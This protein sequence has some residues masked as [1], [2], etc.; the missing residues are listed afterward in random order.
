[1]RR[2][3]PHLQHSRA[4]RDRVD[5]APP[6]QVARAC[7]GEDDHRG[8]VGRDVTAIEKLEVSRCRLQPHSERV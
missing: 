2:V 4:R 8:L 3:N 5:L 1:M 6:A 7:G